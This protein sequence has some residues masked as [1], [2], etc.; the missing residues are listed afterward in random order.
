MTD[1]K[2]SIVE[3]IGNT[4]L[5]DLSPFAALHGCTE[6]VRLLAKVESFNPGGSVKD[7][8][9]RAI[10]EAAE[11]SGALPVGGTIV[12]AT[13]GNT[14]IALAMVGAAKGYSVVIAMPASMSKERRAIMR[15]LGAELILTEPTLGMKGAVQAAEEYVEANPGSILASQFTNP[16]NVQAHYQTTGP[17]IWAQTGGQIDFF[18][19]GVG[20]GGTISGVGTF[21]KECL[22]DVQIIAAEPAESPLLSEGKAGPH[23]IQGLGANFVPQILKVELIDRIV[24]VEG[25]RAMEMARQVAKETGILCGISSGA[26]LAASIEVGRDQAAAGKTIVTVL[27]DG[28]ERY[29][30]TP[31]YSE[32]MD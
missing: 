7:R 12:E 15:A 18:V 14:G 22:Q 8:I 28:G 3:T 10:V 23:A 30:S 29:L 16:A 26:A 32:Y 9:A 31:L 2:S 13:S 24:T 25:T 1:V 6:G 19:A 27:P 21:L 11:R 5:V 20:T 17:E 4:P